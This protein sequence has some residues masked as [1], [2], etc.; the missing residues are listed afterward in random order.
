MDIKN[1][2]ETEQQE[3]YRLLNKMYGKER[4]LKYLFDVDCEVDE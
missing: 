4:I 1:L 2:T 3:F